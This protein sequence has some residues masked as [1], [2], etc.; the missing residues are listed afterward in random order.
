MSTPRPAVKR[1]YGS[2]KASG[3]PAGSAAVSSPSRSRRPTAATS[4]LPPTS[5]PHRFRSSRTAA[6]SSD[7]A[8]AV[9]E[10]FTQDNSMTSGGGKRGG[11]QGITRET[12]PEPEGRVLRGGKTT[13]A[14]PPAPKPKGDL[15]SFFARTSPRKRR[16]LSSPVDDEDEDSDAPSMARSSS[17]GSSA[18]SSSRLSST[19]TVSSASS[20]SKPPSF[21]SSSKPQ[22]LEQLYLDPF[23]TA[24]HATLSC[25]Q[26]A[27][28]YARTPED[29]AF[30]A[31]H[32]KKVVSGV[33]WT[34][35][36]DGKGVSVL[37]DAVEWAGKDGGKVVCVDY[38]VAEAATKRK[39]KDVL[40]TIDTELSSTSLT[41][42]QLAQSKVFLFVTPQRKVVAAAVIQR[43]KEAYEVV[44][45]A[46][47]GVKREAAEEVEPE[48]GLLRFGEEEGAIFCS[49][50][51]LPTLLGV[52]RIWTS[53]SSRR[54]GLATLLL[55]HVAAKFVYGCAVP[56]ERRKLDFA[57]SQPTGK[58]QKLA[59]AFTETDGF[60]VF[61]D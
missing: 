58:G 28:S 26:C 32:H 29:M 59:K 27:L 13:P 9:A 38:P 24:G 42:T 48:R 41:P 2:R 50:I 52:Q 25:P 3:T 44:T 36:D 16:R 10:S 20:S 21:A 40:E 8:D 5:S 1:Q 6:P 15:R 31:K 43:I 54:A 49:P 34:A 18:S 4:S 55:D 30:H 33:D 35:A 37:E 7:W 47:D 14:K 53:T 23:S 39:L 45:S 60:R 51:P 57:F 56:P 19:T 22:K 46:A 61:V 11:M 12:T 17:Y